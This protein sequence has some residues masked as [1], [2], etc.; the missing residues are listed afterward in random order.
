MT[1]EGHRLAGGPHLNPPWPQGAPVT[2][3]PKAFTCSALCSLQ[4]TGVHTVGSVLTIPCSISI[5]R[6][7][8]RRGTHASSEA[9]VQSC[10]RLRFRG[11]QLSLACLACLTCLPLPLFPPIRILF[12]ATLI[13]LS[14][15][16]VCQFL[17]LETALPP[18]ICNPAQPFMSLL[19]D[20][21]ATSSRGLSWTPSHSG[22]DAL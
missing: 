7:D 18:F 9:A 22:L 10:C 21:P 8:K 12:R 19:L 16:C 14:G 11:R 4:D 17:R 15:L 1:P 3:A 20:L 5:C 6:M 13:F 2:P